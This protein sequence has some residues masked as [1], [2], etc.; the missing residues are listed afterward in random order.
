MTAALWYCCAQVGPLVIATH[1]LCVNWHPDSL[2]LSLGS[3]YSI[4]PLNPN[5][6]LF[7]STKPCCGALKLT[8]MN[9]HNGSLQIHLV[10]CPFT[11][12][13]ICGGTC[14]DSPLSL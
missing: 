3:L 11:D 9:S 6:Y 4:H 8:Y 14:C 7:Y 1:P 5:T 13:L 10:R 2:Y 12:S